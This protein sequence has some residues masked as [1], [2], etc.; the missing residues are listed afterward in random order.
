MNKNY[1]KHIIL[2]CILIIGN[3]SILMIIII[4]CAD[5]LIINQD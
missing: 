3:S 5:K 2:F 4:N 1:L